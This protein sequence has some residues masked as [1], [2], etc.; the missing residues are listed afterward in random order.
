M[1]GFS[2]LFFLFFM[3]QYFEKAK[4]WKRRLPVFII[5]FALLDFGHNLLAQKKQTASSKV[6]ET[7]NV[8][9]R[10]L[11]FIENKGQWDDQARFL[12]HTNGMNAWVTNQGITYDFYKRENI[13]DAKTSTLPLLNKEPFGSPKPPVPMKQSGHVVAMRFVNISE[14]SQQTTN[15]SST[16]SARAVGFNQQPGYFNYLHGNDRSKWAMDVASYS[17]VTL[18]QIYSGIDAKLYYD[19]SN[20]RYD[21][22]IAAGKDPGQ[23]AIAFDGTDDIKINPKGDLI[24]T[25]SLG[26]VVQGKLFAYQEQNGKKQ[27]IECSFTKN[28]VNNGLSSQTQRGVKSGVIQFTLGKYDRSKP[29]VIDPLVYLTYLGASGGTEEGVSGEFKHAT[30]N[31]GYTYIS[32]SSVM[33]DYPITVGAYQTTKSDYSDAVVTKLNSIGALVYSTYIGGNQS[34]EATTLSV[35]GGGN[36]YITGTSYGSGSTYPITAGAW[37][38]TSSYPYLAFITKINPAGNGLIYSTFLPIGS[39]NIF[40]ATVDKN[41]CLYFVE[42]RAALPVT[43]GAYDATNILTVGDVKNVIKLNAAGSAP[44]FVSKVN[45]G[46]VPSIAVDQQGAIYLGSYV[47]TWGYI[48]TLP[49]QQ[50]TSVPGSLVTKL[51]SDGA[52]LAYSVMI[53]PNISCLAVDSSGNACAAGNLVTKINS[54]GTGLIYEKNNLG[55]TGYVYGIAADASGAAYVAGETSYDALPVTSGAFQSVF[56][57]SKDVF[58]AKLNPMGDTDYLSYLGGSANDGLGRIKIDDSGAVYV[59]GYTFSDALPVTPGVVQSTKKGVTDLFIAKFDG[60]PSVFPPTI[61]GFTPI[62]SCSGGTITITGANFIGTTSVSFGGV[63]A[64]SYTVNGTGTVITAI[65]AAGASGNVAVT[66]PSGTATLPGFTFLPSAIISG[67]SPST[68]FSGSTVT[69]SG[70]GFTNATS[71]AFGGVPASSFT[72]LNDNQISAVVGFG[73]SGN[74]SVQ[75]LCGAATLPGFTFTNDLPVL[76]CTALSSTGGNVVTINGSNLTGVVSVKFGGVNA[77]SFT[78]MS[79]TQITATVA[80]GSTSGTYAVTNPA[81]TASCAMFTYIPTPPIISSFNPAFGVNPQNVTISGTN[82]LGTTQVTFGGVPATIVSV[83]DTKIVATLGVGTVSST[84]IVVAVTKPDGTASLNGFVY[85]NVPPIPNITSFSPVCGTTGTVVTIDGTGFSGAKSV[86]FGGTPATFTIVNDLQILATVKSGASGSVTVTSLS[87]THSLPGFTYNPLPT[88]SGFTPNNPDAGQTLIINGTNFTAPGC[89]ETV[90][91]LYLGGNLVPPGNI[92]IVSPTQLSVVVPANASSGTVQLI[93]TD[94]SN[95]TRTGFLFN[96]PRPISFTPTSGTTGTA[97]VITGQNFSGTSGAAGVKINGVNAASYTVDSDTQITAYPAATTALTGSITVTNSNGNGSA[98]TFTF[99]PPPFVDGFYS[100]RGAIGD[101]V[102]IY[103]RNF[104]GATAVKFGATNSNDGQIGTILSVSPT[105]ITAII[106][107]GTASGARRIYVQTPAGNGFSGTGGTRTFLIGA[108]TAAP[109]VTSISPNP[110]SQQDSVLTITGTNLSTTTGVLLNGVPLYFTATPSATTVKVRIPVGATGG[111][112]TLYT[113]GGT[114]TTP[115]VTILP[116]PTITSFTPT[117]GGTGTVV[118]IT[119]TGFTGVS[120]AASVRFGATNAASYT[121]N[122]DTQITATVAAGSTGQVRIIA[123][124]GT[125]FS[126]TNFTYT[127]PPPAPTMTNVSTDIGTTGT[128][129]VIT[130]TNFARGVTNV[131]FGG[132][133][134]TIIS[135]SGTQIQVAVGA[136]NSGNIV[137]T[138]PSGSANSNAALGV[139][140]TYL[141]HPIPTITSFNTSGNQYGYEGDPVIIVGNYLASTSRITI[142]GALVT[143]F[144]VN[145]NGSITAT[146]PAGATTGKIIIYKDVVSPTNTLIAQSAT[147]YT[148]LALFAFDKG[149]NLTSN[150]SQKSVF[151]GVE[152]APV[153][154]MTVFPNPAQSAITVQTTLTTSGLV[155]L[156]LLN[157]LGA[158]VWTAEVPVQAGAF[159][160]QIE[161]SNLPSGFYITELRI[162]AERLTKRFV[163]Q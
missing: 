13:D 28:N 17:D 107:S 88:I 86:K 36:A 159:E 30:D 102:T 160:R 11:V 90:Q 66:T 93:R 141:P 112:L 110:V 119:G 39:Y 115:V 92:T 131:T 97:V 52:N 43:S 34:D 10:T 126:A 142:G 157:A 82:F 41:G 127:T 109:T 85:S 62:S 59:M 99:T 47:G 54:S 101:T 23:I 51:S 130:G 79:A 56:G 74:V 70:S 35:D 48:T 120:G 144:V 58:F 77:L 100:A 137:V 2:Y 91:N 29:L 7:V 65:L 6:L 55:I 73:T 89:G 95:A 4:Q 125:V 63:P 162:G 83:T 61:T 72:I 116:L 14:P 121:V 37:S 146:V 18:Q 163:K 15:L 123:P 156:S 143:S 114:V 25:T 113:Q 152:N 57:G 145:A 138:T 98:S 31:Q 154:G 136:G 151:A 96:A 103:G 9:A 135:T 50:L 128:V 134:G 148:V 81:G 133:A 19:G 22:V 38:N 108:P 111:A 149:S 16:E 87:G 140:F 117:S 21:L 94:N 158:T 64:V 132:V 24:L 32:G 155:R 129:V 68:A 49:Q 26:D 75:T 42:G 153:T 106:Q 78:I 147:D 118:T 3:L 67:F 53:K 69:I 27:Q 45:A 8:K 84:P 12:A 104:T 105:Q 33:T 20:I 44:I 161:L 139:N 124:G 150:E 71:I 122:S 60:L 5:V 80:F 40:N 1:R 46:W 76:A